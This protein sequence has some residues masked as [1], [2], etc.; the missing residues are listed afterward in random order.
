MFSFIQQSFWVAYIALAQLGYWPQLDPFNPL[1]VLTLVAAFIFG[2]WYG[3]WL[4][5]YWYEVV[6]ERAQAR[7]FYAFGGK[8]SRGHSSEKSEKIERLPWQ[9]HDAGGPSQQAN[10]K[11][12]HLEDL[13]DDRE[14]EPDDIS[15]R[16]EP[17][18]G[19]KHIIVSSQE[20]PVKK[21]ERKS[22]S[23]PVRPRRTSG[24]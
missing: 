17:D 18:S 15:P 16:V 2:M 6:Y 24:L 21:R 13:L 4:G 5:L 7:W 23:K 22:P 8:R 14:L 20:V 10:A 12:W 19:L 11:R 1:P 9:A 3:I